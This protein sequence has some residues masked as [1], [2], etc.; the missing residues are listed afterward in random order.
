[1]GRHFS[2][3]DIQMA[4]RHMKKC[5]ILLIIREYKSKLQWSV[6]S[7]QSEWTSLKCLKIINAGE[8]VDKKEPSY[9]V[10]GNVN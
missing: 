2:T 8:D 1:M 3:E 10:S 5:L 6:I 4:N 7:H 9:T